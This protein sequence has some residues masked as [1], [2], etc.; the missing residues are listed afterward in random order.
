M[1]YDTKSTRTLSR[2]GRYGL[3]VTV[4]IYWSRKMKLKPGDQV[5]TFVHPKNPKILC[6]EVPKK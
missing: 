1:K 4:D 5:T 3:S 6:I 2:R